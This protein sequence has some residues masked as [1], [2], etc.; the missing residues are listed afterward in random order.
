VWA[1]AEMQRLLE[2]Q[3]VVATKAALA[4]QEVTEVNM[5]V[6]MSMARLRDEEAATIVVPKSTEESLRDIERLMNLEGATVSAAPAV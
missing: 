1:A 2:A 6:H 3:V 5:D 4:A